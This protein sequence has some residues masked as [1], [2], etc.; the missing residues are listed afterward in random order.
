MLMARPT[1][2]SLLQLLV[3][4]V[5]LG[6]ACGLEAG[7]VASLRSEIE[8]LLDHVAHATGYGINVGLVGEGLDMGIGAG[9][10]NPVGLPRKAAPGNVTGN[11][12]YIL[13]SGTKPFTATAIMRLVDAGKIS[14]DDPA[15]TYLDKP[16]QAMWNTTLVGLFGA[17]AA[18]ITV[19]HL[20]RMRTGLNDMD[21][22]AFDDTML[23]STG[24]HSPLLDLQH[25]ANFT[26]PFGP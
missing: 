3:L 21:T 9:P 13:G 2:R 17:R 20:I 18:K 12:T 16:M 4:I 6:C 22:P 11:D 5:L 23:N 19:G 25:V 15:S 1:A 24:L 7:R 10:R 14:L 26:Q 8:S